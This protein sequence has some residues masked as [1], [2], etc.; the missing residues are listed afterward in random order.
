ML[1]FIITYDK[2][3]FT[4]LAFLCVALG[5]VYVK[6][7]A[8]YFQVYFIVYMLVTSGIFTVLLLQNLFKFIF[9][10]AIKGFS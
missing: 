4:A 1:A 2:F 7:L 10:L 8:E 3:I 9:Y 5:I 6:E